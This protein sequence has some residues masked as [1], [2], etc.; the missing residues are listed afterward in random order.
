[1]QH[2]LHRKQPAK[3]LIYSGQAKNTITPY[4]FHTNAKR[5]PVVQGDGIV[6]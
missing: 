5:N 6:N 4:S 3:S 1:M 2:A